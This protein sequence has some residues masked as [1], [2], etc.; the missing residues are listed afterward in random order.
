MDP[1]TVG[2]ITGGASLIGS[3]FNSTTTAQNTQDQ[4]ASQQA[5][6]AQSEQYN[7]Q[8]AQLNRD[9]Q[10]QQVAGQQQFGASQVAGQQQFNDY[11]R[12]QQQS[13]QEQMSNTAYQRS[14]A[15][16]IKAG[17]NPMLMAGMGGASTPSGSAPSSGVASSSAASGS[18]ASIGTPNVPM[19]Q[20]TSALAG[21]GKAA[22][23]V[24]SSAVQAKSFDRMTDE[25]ANLKA[26]RDRIIAETGTEQA[27][28]GFVEAS[29]K[30]EQARPENIAQ[31]TTALKL[32]RARQEWEA[33][34]YLDLSNVPDTIRKM[35]NIGGW[36]ANK[37]NDVITPIVNSAGAVRG[38]LPQSMTRE[39][40]RMYDP[41]GSGSYNEFWKNRTGFGN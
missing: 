22:D 32:D 9:F 37:I 1:L 3:I 10:A 35:G 30:T 36:S 20:R 40:G 21:L 6:Q 24:V 23:D 13:F 11:E 33:M 25:I 15:D 38:F 16:M 5:M 8:Q 28:K 29:T 27:R 19:S 26:T 12:L 39:G 31:Q 14:R 41:G 2:L 17:L 18:T 4:I 7:A 34:K